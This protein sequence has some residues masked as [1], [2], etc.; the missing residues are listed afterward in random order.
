MLKMLDERIDLLT[1]AIVDDAQAEA[2]EIRADA[3]AKAAEI[4]HAAKVSAD[5]IRRDILTKA[6]QEAATFE[7]EIAAEGKM[8]AQ[9]LWLDRREKLISQVFETALSRIP[10]ILENDQY[11]SVL[12]ELIKEAAL[13][14]QSEAVILH[15]DP[16]SR[17]L[18]T[19]DMLAAIFNQTHQTFTF[20]D[21]LTSGT[22]VVAETQ[23]G[24]RQYDNTLEMRL[25]RQQQSLRAA[26]F[27]ILMG[28][29]K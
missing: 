4:E 12:Q 7:E 17:R 25:R 19:D 13:N 6:Q 2:D 8:K 21:D 20:G 1:K 9:M 14:T 5:E 22:G 10:S 3:R 18:A 26:V 29:T 28:E 27:H 16:F 15:F 24:H 23:D 11:P